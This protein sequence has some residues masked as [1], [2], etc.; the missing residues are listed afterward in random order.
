MRSQTS[1]VAAGDDVALEK[2]NLAAAIPTS[3]MTA[4]TMSSGAT[5]V[6]R[7]EHGKSKRSPDFLI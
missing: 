4:S 2:A 7:V 1:S 6:A 3:M 5:D